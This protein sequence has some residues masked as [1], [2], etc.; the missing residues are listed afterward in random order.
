[1]FVAL[2]T[3]LWNSSSSLLWLPWSQGEWWHQVEKVQPQSTRMTAAA[4]L[5]VRFAVVFTLETMVAAVGHSLSE[6]T[7]VTDQSQHSVQKKQSKSRKHWQQHK[8]ME[9]IIAKNRSA[10]WVAVFQH[11]FR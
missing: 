2:L 9:Y 7:D 10:F 6:S 4:H 8:A 1:M 11:C 3:K 5:S